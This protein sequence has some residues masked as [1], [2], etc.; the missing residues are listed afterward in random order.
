VETLPSEANFV[1]FRTALESEA[2]VAGLLRHGV[3]IRSVAGYPELPRFVRVNA[4]T[5]EEN[6]QFLRALDTLIQELP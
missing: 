5:D 4:G 1:V 2:L 6:R 3:L